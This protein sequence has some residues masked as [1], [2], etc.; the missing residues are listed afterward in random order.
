MD[1]QYFRPRYFLVFFYFISLY[2]CLPLFYLYILFHC[3]DLGRP[4]SQQLVSEFD[5]YNG[6]V[7]VKVED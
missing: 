7:Q 3:T 4:I 6:E 1:V 2:Y 5:Y